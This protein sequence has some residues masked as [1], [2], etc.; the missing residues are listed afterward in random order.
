MSDAR[1]EMASKLAADIRAKADELS[2]A[3]Y[4]ASR[5]GYRTSLRI[6]NTIL[7]SDTDGSIRLIGNDK[8]LTIY[9]TVNFDIGGAVL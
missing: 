6:N 7:V 8:P 9:A 5:S 1:Y 2:S 3:I 4:E